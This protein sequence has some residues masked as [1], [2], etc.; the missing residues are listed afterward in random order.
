M[1]V[2]AAIEIPRQ[3]QALLHQ[4]FGFGLSPL[5][6]QDVGKIVQIHGYIGVPLGPEL[7]VSDLPRLLNLPVILVVGLKLGCLNHAILSVENILERGY[8]LAAWVVNQVD[9]GM[10]EVERNVETLAVP[11]APLAILADRAARASWTPPRDGGSAFYDLTARVTY[12]G[13][14]LGAITRTVYSPSSIRQWMRDIHARL[15]E[16]SKEGKLTREQLAYVLLKI[17]KAAVLQRSTDSLSASA[18]DVHRE[19]KIASDRL[20]RFAEL[21]KSDV[22]AQEGRAGRTH[23]VDDV[24]D[25]AVLRVPRGAVNLQVFVRARGDQLE[26]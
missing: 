14:E 24:C 12:D 9:P 17:E 5:Q 8:D 26:L 21:V 20:A 15:V 1:H 18:D 6:A 13:R 3:D 7:D 4:P 19:L 11:A 2:F 22:S 23:A 10:E 25:A 16:L